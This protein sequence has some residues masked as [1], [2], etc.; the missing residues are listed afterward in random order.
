MHTN[1]GN[2][3]SLMG[4]WAFDRVRSSVIHDVDPWVKGSDWACSTERRPRGDPEE[5]RDPVEIIRPVNAS[6][7]PRTSWRTLFFLSGCHEFFICVRHS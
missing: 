5:T 4:G 6:I 3:F 7:F 1:G 2:K